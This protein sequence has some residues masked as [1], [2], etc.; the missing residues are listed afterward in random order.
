MD[1]F[2]DSAYHLSCPYDSY[3]LSNKNRVQVVVTFLK[4]HLRILYMVMMFLEKFDCR[5]NFF[6]G[7][8]NG[9]FTALFVRY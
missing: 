2:F 7:C 1:W 6:F 8:P 4:N 9:F 5:L 3:C